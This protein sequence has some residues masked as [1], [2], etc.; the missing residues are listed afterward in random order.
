MK[1]II[2]LLSGMAIP[3][4]LSLAREWLFERKLQNKLL[5]ESVKNNAARLAKVQAR[6]DTSFKTEAIRGPDESGLTKSKIGGI[7]VNDH[8]FDNYKSEF[9]KL[10]TEEETLTRLHLEHKRKIDTLMKYFAIQRENPLTK[11]HSEMYQRYINRS[12]T[13]KEISPARTVITLHQKVT[14]K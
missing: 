14:S 8:E 5:T 11:H 2:L 7:E 9:T 4:S 10:R 1:E 13:I 3:F 6:L 12:G